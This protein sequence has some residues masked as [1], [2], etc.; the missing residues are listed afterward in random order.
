MRVNRNTVAKAYA[1]LE[2]QGVI[3]TIPGKGCFL[4]EVNS[5]FTKSAR[6]RSAR[7]R[8][9][10]RPSSPR[11]TC[12]WTRDDFLALVKE[13]LDSF[14]AQSNKAAND[15]KGP[16]MNT[17]TPVIEI[18]N[19]RRRYGK[20]DAVNGLSLTVRAGKCYGFF[21][22]NGA[23]KTTTIKCLLNL[24]RPDFR[25]GARVRPRP[26]QGRSGRQIAA[27]LRAGH[28]GVLSVDDRARHA[29]IPRLVP[30][31]IGTATSKPIC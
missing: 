3:E 18:Q 17:D 24:L 25:H 22:R 10:T 30:H 16:P 4:K 15:S 23:G 11:I 26:A 14:R 8:K 27:G 2:S 6:N 28:G 12:R 31:N 13:R 1:E 19:L 29:G 9:L 21:G 5:P 7:R 20:L